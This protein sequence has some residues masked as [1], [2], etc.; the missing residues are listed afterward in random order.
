M[1]SHRGHR[2][3][4]ALCDASSAPAQAAAVPNGAD[5]PGA[6]VR[7]RRDTGDA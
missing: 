4:K 6:D 2:P 3:A 5:V 1:A 7:L